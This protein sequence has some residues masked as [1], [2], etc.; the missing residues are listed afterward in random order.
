MLENR[1]G[2]NLLAVL[3]QI[4]FDGRV[5]KCYIVNFK[6]IIVVHEIK[7]MKFP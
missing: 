4:A 1:A 2:F 5:C 7:I 3:V 6:K